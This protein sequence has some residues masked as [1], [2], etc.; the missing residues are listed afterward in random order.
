M[1]TISL[2]LAAAL[3]APLAP[4]QKNNDVLL[5]TDGARMRGLEISELLLTGVRGKRNAGKDDFELPASLVAD[6]EWGN[7]PE[8]FLAGRS[9]LQRGDFAAATQFF[10]DVKTDRP[11]IQTDAEFFLVKAAVAA[12]GTDRN[13]AATAAERAKKWLTDHVNHWR[14]PEAMLLAGRAERFAGLGG[15]AAATLRELDERALRDSFGA[16]WSARAK[17]ELAMTLLADGKGGE[18]RSAFTSTATAAD[19]A[20]GKPSPAD[21]ELRELKTQALVGEGETY[22]VEKDFGRAESFFLDLTSGREPLLVPVGHAGAGEAIFHAAQASKKPSDFRRA[23]LSLAKASVLDRQAGE[24]SAKANY[25]LGR[26]LLELGVEHEGDSFRQRAN[27]YF[28]LVLSNYPSSRF[29]AL[30]KLELGR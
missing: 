26:C 30:A 16:V 21:A 25:Y 7:L 12:A 18:A 14:T 11:L 6:V 1:R 17:F 3:L 19:A 2:L 29:A 22:L 8:S 28:Q 9:A 13:A 20:L 27:A 24:A 15:A 5:R 10:G 4:A 23:Q